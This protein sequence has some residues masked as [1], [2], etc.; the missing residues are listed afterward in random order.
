MGVLCV[1]DASGLVAWTCFLHIIPAVIR[2]RYI[3]H[4]MDVDFMQ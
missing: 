2:V 1:N 4:D 3:W